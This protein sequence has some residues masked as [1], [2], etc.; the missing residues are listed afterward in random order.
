LVA[1]GFALQRATLDGEQA[2]ELWEVKALVA[3]LLAWTA[4]G[5]IDLAMLF[6]FLPPQAEAEAVSVDA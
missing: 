3:S 4:A 2:I 1:L 6:K 5:L